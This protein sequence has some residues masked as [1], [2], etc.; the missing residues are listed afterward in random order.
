MTMH[1]DDL[2]EPGNYYNFK[3]I[4]TIM[5]H[6]FLCGF[7]LVGTSVSAP[8][9]TVIINPGYDRFAARRAFLAA[10]IEKRLARKRDRNFSIRLSVDKFVHGSSF[11]N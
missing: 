3:F 7:Y 4:L 2:L 11:I 8:H 6:T 5:S 10:L 9:T 1:H